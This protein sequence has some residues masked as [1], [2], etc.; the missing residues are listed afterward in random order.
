[1]V[2]ITNWYRI[3]EISQKDTAYVM[4]L[5][6]A[7]KNKDRRNSGSKWMLMILIVVMVS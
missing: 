2:P 3:S 4:F 7:N 1:M 5:S 6:Y